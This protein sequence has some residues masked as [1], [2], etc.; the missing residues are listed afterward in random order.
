MR[1]LTHLSDKMLFLIILSISFL[2]LLPIYI[3]PFFIT[4]DGFVHIIREN[5]YVHAF[6]AGQFPPRWADELNYGYGSPIFLVFYPL[7]GYATAILHMLGL[8][9]EQAYVFFLSLCFII[10]PLFWFI[11]AK[12]IT[13]KNFAFLA[14]IFSTV[15]PYRFLTTFVRGSIGE[16][17]AFSLIPLLLYSVDAKKQRPILGSLTF[18][19]ILLSHNGISLMIT[20]VFI[21]Y[22]LLKK[23]PLSSWIP[24]IILGLGIS[25]YFWIPSLLE[26]KYTSFLIFYKDMYKDHFAPLL[27]LIY[28][29][30]GF[31]DDIN[32]IGGLSAQ[33]GIPAL[34]LMIVSTFILIKKGIKK[35]V[36]ILFWIF[37]F[38]G[39]IFLSVQASNF[40][41]EKSDFIKKFQFPWRFMFYP[42]I[43]SGMVFVHLY[44]KM[45]MK[46][47]FV[48]TLFSTV[49]ALPFMKVLPSSTH[50]D[51]YYQSYKGSSTFRAEATP[52]WSPGDPEKKFKSPIEIIEGEGEISNYQ[53]LSTVHTFDVK[54]STKITV[55]DN[56]LYF[57]GW[58]AYVDNE[59]TPIQ[60]QD[61]H[62]QG[63][64]TFSINEGNHAVKI[65]FKETKIRM[66]ANFISVA[67]LFMTIL[68]FFKKKATTV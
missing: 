63:L 13:D 66:I 22:C 9:L 11:W 40:I 47:F 36:H 44:K 60:F 68:F 26:S 3:H 29:P 15:L 18:G 39:G 38:T 42:T 62:H 12:E 33:I 34:L 53:R 25:S 30:W 19:L 45:S 43:A 49:Y 54:S 7:A 1:S 61:P 4:H 37:L 41:W 20:P 21:V 23:Y 2:M 6:L 17:L 35:N 8:S 5:A 28:S 64:I 55:L 10:G 31:D 59:N 67:S 48:I 24:V 58:T 57:P 14:T 51:M 65:A 56:T 27:H 32:K 50:S 52:I 46:F 16:I